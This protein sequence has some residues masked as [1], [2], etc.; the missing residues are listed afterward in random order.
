MLKA[1]VLLSESASVP[2]IAGIFTTNRLQEIANDLGYTKLHEIY[3][4]R[5]LIDGEVRSHFDNM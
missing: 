1:A 4:I 5:Y 2:A 3:Y